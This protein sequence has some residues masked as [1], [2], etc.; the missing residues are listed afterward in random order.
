M[1]NRLTGQTLRINKPGQRRAARGGR[2]HRNIDFIIRTD[3]EIMN[4][5]ISSSDIRQRP[6][7]P[8]FYSSVSL[9]AFPFVRDLGIF[10]KEWK[11]TKK[12]FIM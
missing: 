8:Q 4:V 11:K 7:V 6:P 12:I 9:L 10:V 3:V 2:P 1:P 5:L